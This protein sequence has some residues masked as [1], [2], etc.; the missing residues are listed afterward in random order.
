MVDDVTKAL[1]PSG[2]ATANHV[3]TAYRGH[4]QT[5]P[6][7][8][9]SFNIGRLKCPLHDI[10]LSERYELKRARPRSEKQQEGTSSR[11]HRPQERDGV[12]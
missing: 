3:A 6:M 10:L 1:T 5:E 2:S 8:P 4:A 7:G 12:C 11:G 9:F